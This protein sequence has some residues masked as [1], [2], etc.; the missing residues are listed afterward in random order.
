MNRCKGLWTGC[1]RLHL[2]LD[3]GWCVE[4]ETLC[5][6][7]NTCTYFCIH[8]YTNIIYIHIYINMICTFIRWIVPTNTFQQIDLLRYRKQHILENNFSDQHS[9]QISLNIPIKQTFFRA[10]VKCCIYSN[11]HNFSRVWPCLC[12]KY[13]RRTLIK[14]VKHMSTMA[15]VEGRT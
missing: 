10:G 11:S 8:A 9:P 5:I 3:Q 7:S 4:K 12:R 2:P 13:K 6:L 14:T 15:A 1:S